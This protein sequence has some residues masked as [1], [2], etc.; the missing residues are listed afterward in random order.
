MLAEAAC[1]VW[2]GPGASNPSGVNK[3]RGV[4]HSGA[5]KQL[6]SGNE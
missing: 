4:W 6:V 3:P 5:K 2:R 1:R